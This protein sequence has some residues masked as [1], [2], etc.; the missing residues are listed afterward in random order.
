MFT[1]ARS[2]PGLTVSAALMLTA[3]T[4]WAL[5][6]RSQRI[7]ERA[8]ARLA[9]A[10]ARA[11]RAEAWVVEIAP[12]TPLPPPPRPATVRR[13]LRAGVPLGSPIV[14]WTGPATAVAST[15][16]APMA[17]E[18]VTVRPAAPGGPA[19]ASAPAQT[20]PAIQPPPAGN[21]AARPAKP[22]TPAASLPD[23]VAADGS[24]SV[25]TKAEAPAADAPPREP[26]GPA[27]THPPIELLPTP[28]PQ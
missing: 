23:D 10:E 11:A 20:P 13:M 19:T 1:P 8:Y 5:P 16:P 26:A 28:R 2:L 17:R 14:V 21:T 27:V 7:A 6:P 15:G 3:G 25:L 12:T 4:A 9:I 18:T 24:R 22:Q